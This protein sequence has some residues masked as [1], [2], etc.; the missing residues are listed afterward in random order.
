MRNS[1]HFE[2][3]MSSVLLLVY[4]GSNLIFLPF[5]GLSA[6]DSG[7]GGS[8]AGTDY[9]GVLRLSSPCHTWG[10]LHLTNQ[11]QPPPCCPI[12]AFPLLN[13]SPALESR[14]TPLAGAHGRAPAAGGHWS[15]RSLTF[16]QP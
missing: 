9:C 11:P 6:S 16:P 7:K 12:A 1:L 14:Y 3:S 8:L 4:A 2:W 13:R 10:C 5:P 15:S